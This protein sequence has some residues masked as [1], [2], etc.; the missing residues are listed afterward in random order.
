MR[1]PADC[2]AAVAKGRTNY[3]KNMNKKNTQR[4]KYLGCYLLSQASVSLKGSREESRSHLL[5]EWGE[6]NK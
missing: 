1:V 4:P 2:L 6:M 5:K 3:L